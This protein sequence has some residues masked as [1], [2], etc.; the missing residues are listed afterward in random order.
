MDLATL[1]SFEGLLLTLLKLLY[2]SQQEL[3]HQLI[4]RFPSGA[5]NRGESLQ[6]IWIQA[7]S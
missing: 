2:C 6:D 4:E 3:A 5:G 1:L 7:D